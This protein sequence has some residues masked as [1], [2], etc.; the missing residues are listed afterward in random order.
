MLLNNFSLTKGTLY[1]AYWVNMSKIN[2]NHLAV[3]YTRK[4]ASTNLHT[5]HNR[6][7]TINPHLLAR[8][9]RL[10]YSLCS[11]F[12]RF[13]RAALCVHVISRRNTECHALVKNTERA[14]THMQEFTPVTWLFLWIL[15]YKCLCTFKLLTRT[16]IGHVKKINGQFFLIN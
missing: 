2:P 3:G 14:R 4:I 7:R 16:K 13:A 15:I 12:V 8:K 1:L 9:E 5:L 10:M 11:C 6:K